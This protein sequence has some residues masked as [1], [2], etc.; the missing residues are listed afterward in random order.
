MVSSVSIHSKIACRPWK[1]VWR[2]SRQPTARKSGTSGAIPILDR[3]ARAF[4]EVSGAL[5]FGQSTRT[6]RCARTA[7]SDEATRY[8]STP[9]STRRVTAPG[10]SL[11]C[12]VEKTR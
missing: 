12:S 11:V 9:M 6:R 2:H 4:A 3:K 8:G 7:S 5:H 1:P 10:A